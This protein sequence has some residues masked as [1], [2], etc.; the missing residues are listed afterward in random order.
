MLRRWLA[1]KAPN[2]DQ[3]KRYALMREQYANLAV[4]ISQLTPEGDDQVHA[5]RLLRQSMMLANA[6]IANEYEVF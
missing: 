6:A 1:Y 5:L 2:D 3:Q 4:T